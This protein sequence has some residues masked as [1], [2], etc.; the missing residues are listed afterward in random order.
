MN[1][2]TIT[3]NWSYFDRVYCISVKERRDRRR[4]SLRQF[5]NVGLADRIEYILVDRHPTN[6]EQ[7]IYE[8]HLF[9]IRKGLTSGANKILIFE[10]DVI[11][12]R[13]CPLRFNAGI[14]FLTHRKHWNILFLGCLV[15]QS[16]KTGTPSIRKIGYRCLSHAYAIK[17]PFAQKLADKH[18]DQIPY[19]VMLSR[20]NA[21]MY[22]CYPS[23]AFQSDSVSDNDRHLRLDTFRRWCG[24][25]RRIQKVNE[26]YHC[27]KKNIIL[28]HVIGLAVLAW[29]IY[30]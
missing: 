30:Y 8:S 26:W 25:L 19:D 13:F 23:F 10:D 14:R 12:Q 18:W 28:L 27:H 17:R 2:N 29:M 7:G 22:I 11:F 6:C 21:N 1:Q 3:A 15:K 5:E 16:Q 4:E 20:F 9:C 24:G